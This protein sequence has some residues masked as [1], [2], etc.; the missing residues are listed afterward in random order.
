MDSTLS[1]IQS[2]LTEKIVKK[3]P[4]IIK[5]ETENL[6]SYLSHSFSYEFAETTKSFECC[7]KISPG[8][9]NGCAVEKSIKLS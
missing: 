1:K 3:F 8:V 6:I 4:F 5:F 2:I 9:N 7:R